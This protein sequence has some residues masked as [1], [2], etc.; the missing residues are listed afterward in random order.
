MEKVENFVS[1]NFS[2][3]LYFRMGFVDAAFVDELEQYLYQHIVR[4]RKIK[5]ESLSVGYKHDSNCAEVIRYEI[6]LATATPQNAD[7]IKELI[8]EKTNAWVS[9]MGGKNSV[10]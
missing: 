8:I 10:Y 3:Y 5:G 6:P 4:V 1:G 2:T 9:S 7:E